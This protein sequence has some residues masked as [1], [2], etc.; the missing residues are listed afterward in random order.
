MERRTFLRSIALVGGATGMT[1]CVSPIG[2]D[3]HS[4][5][6]AE[7]DVSPTEDL[8][9]EHGVLKRV[10]LVYRE[11][12]RRLAT[13]E[14]LPP[15]TLAG[16]ARIIRVFIEDYHEKLEEDFLFPRFRKPINKLN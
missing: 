3:V 8:M 10:I 11:A 16:A 6:P 12:L 9:R 1:G 7:E 4:A 5:T 13:R 2:T 14:D 15:E